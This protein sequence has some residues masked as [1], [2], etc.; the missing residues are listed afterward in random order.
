MPSLHPL[1]KRPAPPSQLGP[2]CGIVL[3]MTACGSLFEAGEAEPQQDKG[4]GSRTG[5]GGGDAMSPAEDAG[6]GDGAAENSRVDAVPISDSAA[7]VEAMSVPAPDGEGLVADSGGGAGGASRESGGT[8]GCVSAPEVCDGKDNDCNGI[9]DDAPACVCMAENF[10][11]RTYQ[12]CAKGR[13]WAEAAAF[14]SEHGYHL[15][16]IDS[17]AEDRWLESTTRLIAD[18][19]WWMGYNDQVL[20]KHWVWLDG[21][22]T[23]YVHWA[24]GQPNN[25]DGR[26]DCGELNRFAPLTGWND[27]PCE[28]VQPFVCESPVDGSSWP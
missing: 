6:N 7:N 15:V 14:C 17:E 25:K 27:Q 22:A 10:G 19:T 11:G 18:T 5:P 26:E 4:G 1:V 24:A 8:G 12:F 13:P 21:S 9:V 23:T 20:E 16:T 28:D 3:F 2:A